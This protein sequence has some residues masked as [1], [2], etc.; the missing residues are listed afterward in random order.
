[1]SKLAGKTAIVTGGASGIGR[2]VCEALAERGAIVTVADLDG[3]GAEAVARSI[4]GRGGRAQGRPL[5][6]RDAAAVQK[7]VDDTAAQHGRLDYMFNNA[8]IAIG[9]EER[10]VSLEDW[11]RVLDVDLHGV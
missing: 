1:M 2:A 5:D 9:G 10:D 3:A 8:G 7:L 11:N 4:S 6:V